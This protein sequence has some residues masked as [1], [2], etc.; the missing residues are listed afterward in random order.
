MRPRLNA[1]ENAEALLKDGLE[2]DASMRPQLNAAE[3]VR[4]HAG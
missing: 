3:N 2:P 4:M 1:A